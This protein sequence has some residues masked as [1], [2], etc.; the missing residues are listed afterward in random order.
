MINHGLPAARARAARLAAAAARADGPG[1]YLT[2]DD[3]DDTI[4]IIK[5]IHSHPIVLQETLEDEYSMGV[6]R[7]QTLINAYAELAVLMDALHSENEQLRADVRRDG[8]IAGSAAPDSASA[9][10]MASNHTEMAAR[11]AA[12]E[13]ELAGRDDAILALQRQGLEMLQEAEQREVEMQELQVSVQSLE[14]LKQEQ[15]A[16]ERTMARLEKANRTLRH[17]AEAKGAALAQA[18]LQAQGL[19]ARI[20]SLEER[21][22]AASQPPPPYMLLP[23]ATAAV[24]TPDPSSSTG[25][26]AATR[27]TAAILQENA[28][29]R[30]KLATVADAHRRMRTAGDQ[31]LAEVKVWEREA[32]MWQEEANRWRARAHEVKGKDK[33]K[34][35]VMRMRQKT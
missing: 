18:K 16:S 25:A 32:L 31:L 30:H 6:E 22:L 33:G 24:V 23:A 4:A 7:Y 12:L 2:D 1:A 26:A 11:I 34:R 20:E 28:A 10:H 13:A 35:Y 15:V 14:H 21:L 29:L 5:S 9:A 17:K 8:P 19:E 27:P 3:D